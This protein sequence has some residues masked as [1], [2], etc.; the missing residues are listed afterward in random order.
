MNEL[1][2]KP[3]LSGGETLQ[4]FASRLAAINMRPT[5]YPFCK[6][7]GIDLDAVMMG[8]DEGIAAICS[9]G[10]LSFR[11]FDRSLVRQ[12]GKGKWIGAELVPDMKLR[13]GYARFCPLCAQ[14]SL[15]ESKFNFECSLPDHIDQWAPWIETCVEHNARYVEILIPD[16]AKLYT[17]YPV[18]R[19]AIAFHNKE[20]VLAAIQAPQYQ[21]ATDFE[22]Y[23]ARRIRGDA[24]RRELIHDLSLPGLADIAE[25]IGRV[26]FG[27]APRPIE[28][29]DRMRY[30][31]VGFGFISRDY[32]HFRKSMLARWPGENS[33]VL[34]NRFGGFPVWLMKVAQA[35]N[36]HTQFVP[37]LAR[38]IAETSAVG[39]EDLV[40]GQPV[41]RRV[42]HSPI[43]IGS[44]LKVAPPTIW[45]V[46][47]GSGAIND[48]PQSR[49]LSEYLIEA[50]VGDEMIQAIRNATSEA[51]VAKSLETKPQTVR[52]LVDVGVLSHLPGTGVPGVDALINRDEVAELLSELAAAAPVNRSSDDLPI[53]TIVKRTRARVSDLIAAIVERRLPAERIETPVT[54]P[55]LRISVE[56]ALAAIEGPGFVKSSRPSRSVSWRKSGYR[57]GR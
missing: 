5:L 8:R 57:L 24:E 26:F 10:G 17:N 32:D 4:S 35:S 20:A 2:L 38:L 40:M 52:A 29:A 1:R 15:A 11:A 39:P 42:W 16:E 56:A 31:D 55:N 48:G 50:A 25:A 13:R 45:R 41:A 9:L 3:T 30:R 12:D 22:K 54:F 53:L 49:P 44:A 33:F 18:E 46:A 7:L 37:H 47:R 27:K 28:E 36:L 23:I 43:S 21:E 14:R 51:E 19:A 34:P 6:D